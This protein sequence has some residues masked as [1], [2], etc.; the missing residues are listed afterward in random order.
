L[1]RPRLGERRWFTLARAGSDDVRAAVGDLAV[2]W[3]HELRARLGEA[4]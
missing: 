1:T 2:N 4:R 3:L